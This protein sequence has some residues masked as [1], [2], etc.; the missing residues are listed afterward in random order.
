MV[1]LV[2][3]ILKL[4]EVAR[5]PRERCSVQDE[6]NGAEVGLQ[7]MGLRILKINTGRVERP[8][9]ALSQAWIFS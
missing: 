9:K 8:R 7:R 2:H 6:K 1:S 3:N 4:M 5:H